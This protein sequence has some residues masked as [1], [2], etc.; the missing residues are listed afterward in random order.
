MVKPKN[1][2]FSINS[3]SAYYYF[4]TSSSNTGFRLIVKLSNLLNLYL[5]NSK[6]WSLSTDD[7]SCLF[8]LFSCK[9]STKAA[10]GIP[11]IVLGEDKLDLGF[12]ESCSSSFI[13]SSRSNLYNENSS[14]LLKIAW[15]T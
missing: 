12:I 9:L 15:S 11:T 5:S 14:T 4:K 3:P 8:L 10:V 13:F 2:I 7:K 1:S 6:K